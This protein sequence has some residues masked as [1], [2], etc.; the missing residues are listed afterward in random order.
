LDLTF[1]NV[2]RNDIIVIEHGHQQHL[3]LAFSQLS[4]VG[5]SPLLITRICLREAAH[6]KNTSSSSKLRNGPTIDVQSRTRP[7]SYWR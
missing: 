1:W 6:K 7:A 5:L 2:D 4:F 3:Q